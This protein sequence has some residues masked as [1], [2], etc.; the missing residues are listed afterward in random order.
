MRAARFE[1]DGFTERGGPAALSVEGFSTDSVQG[2]LGLAVEGVL[3]LAS[4]RLTLQGRLALAHEFADAA[5]ATL[6]LAASPAARVG[7][8]LGRRDRDWQEAGLTL[9]YEDGPLSLHLAAEADLNRAEAEAL[10][11]RL[12]AAFRF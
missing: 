7:A 11:L 6:A 4:A 2:R 10:D 9:A 5:D 8:G 1:V 12:G 3:P